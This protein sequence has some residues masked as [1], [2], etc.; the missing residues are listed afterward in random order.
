VT[1]EARLEQTDTG[2]V[3]HGDGWFIVNLGE[4]SWWRSETRGTWSG[5]G[6]DQ[7][8]ESRIEMRLRAR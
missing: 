8:L 5:L 2:L 1:D 7:T 4:V 6:P 3:P